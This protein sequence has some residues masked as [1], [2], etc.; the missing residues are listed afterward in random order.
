MKKTILKLISECDEIE[1]NVDS[2][3]TKEIAETVV[4]MVDGKLESTD[5]DY[6]ITMFAIRMYS[7]GGGDID[8]SKDRLWIDYQDQVIPAELC[9]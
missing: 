6:S 5:L 2:L 7:Y 4:K 3:P 8:V 9:C 1:K